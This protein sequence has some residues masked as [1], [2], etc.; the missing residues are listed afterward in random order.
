MEEK[1]WFEDWLQWVG[2]MILA[3][4]LALDEWRACVLK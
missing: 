3:L 1:R 4:A 2:A